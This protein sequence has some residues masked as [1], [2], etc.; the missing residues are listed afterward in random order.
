MTRRRQVTTE[1]NTPT[2]A[3]ASRRRQWKP[4]FIE[5][6]SHTA[7]VTTAAK[8]AGV[9]RSFAYEA[10]HKDPAF[11]MQW[12]EAWDSAIDLL[13]Q[14]AWRRA[15]QGVR[16]PVFQGGAR[17]GWIRE[18]SDALLQQL[19]KGHLPAR[20]R[21]RVQVE[22]TRSPEAMSNLD[23][24]I[25]KS[26]KEVALA[27]PKLREVFAQQ[28]LANPEFVAQLANVVPQ[29]QEGVPSPTESP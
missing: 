21:E 29:G 22:Q 5:V 20:Y 17:V 28:L 10:K 3:R 19:L 23:A 24:E 7:N 1:P 25:L 13:E 8:A 16:K 18:Y 15:V 6:L 27:D 2:R 4:V 12:Q 14:E 9:N 26:L 11:A